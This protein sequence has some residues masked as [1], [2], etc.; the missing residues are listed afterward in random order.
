M[1][2]WT[3]AHGRTG[4]VPDS[5]LVETYGSTEAL[6]DAVD[7][8]IAADLWKREGEGYRMLHG[9]HSDPDMP[10]PLW[11]YSDEDLGSQLFAI[12]DTP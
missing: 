10:L 12:D 2:S 11:R 8:L 1:G 4:Y 3:S 7:R 9:P 5:A 6:T